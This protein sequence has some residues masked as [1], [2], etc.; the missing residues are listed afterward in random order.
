MCLKLKKMAE[1]EIMAVWNVAEWII[2][3]SKFIRFFPSAQ[4]IP[5]EAVINGLK[6]AMHV[7]RIKQPNSNK[8][9]KQT[10]TLQ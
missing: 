2:N 9:N 6:F 5:R 8:T 1:N 7:H 10:K 4:V 3:F